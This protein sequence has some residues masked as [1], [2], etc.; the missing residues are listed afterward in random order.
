[1]R[2]TNLITYKPG[3]QFTS[4]VE[5]FPVE[6]W[7][8]MISVMLTAPFIL[9]KNFL[10]DMKKKGITSREAEQGGGGG[11]GHMPPEITNIQI[12]PFL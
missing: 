9:T 12:C 8:T 6:K 2:F 11:G 3:F 7:N 5:E 10:P 1:M 4:P